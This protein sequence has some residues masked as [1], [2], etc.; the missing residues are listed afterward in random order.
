MIKF[1]NFLAEAQ[2]S[3]GNL[4]KVADIFKRIVQKNLGIKL[5]RFGGDTGFCEIKDGVGILYI[6]QNKKAIR[7]NYIK[8]EIK[9]LTLWNK[10][11]LNKLG[12][13][14]VDL[15][16]LG[17]LEAGKKLI[18]II[19]APAAGKVAAYSSIAESTTILSEATRINPADFYEL[20][21]K[22]LPSGLKI[23]VVPWS[24]ITD[25][26]LSAGFQVPTIVRNTRV[27]G[28]K[29][30]TSR[31]DLTQLISNPNIETQKVSKENEPIYYMKITAQDPLSKKFLSVKGDKKAEDILKRA[32]DAVHNPDYASHM[33]DPDTRFGHMADLVKIVCRGNRNSLVIY[34]GAGIGKTYV[35]T[36]SIKSEGL[37]KGKDWILI[38]G[39]ITTSALYQTLFM[40]RKNTLLVFDDTDSIWSDAEAANILKAALDSYDERTISWISPRNTNVSLMSDDEKESYNSAIDGQIAKDP[41]NGKIK[42]PSEFD[43]SGRIV[44][45]SNLQEDKFDKAV[46]NRSA[47]INMQLTQEEIFTRMKSI[48]QFIGDKNV[49][50][51][52]KEEIFDFI[53]KA[54]SRGILDNVSM[55]T[56]VAAED[57]FKSGMDNWKD[58]LVY[59]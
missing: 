27:A 37:Q 33:L 22:N 46:L 16:G 39:K 51:I 1:R 29:G 14:T 7:L 10:F 38:K 23:S 18:E 43:Y 5:Y 49:P 28:T 21:N 9:S 47:K 57:L 13:F 59:Q 2:V 17:L 48:L 3:K 50:M 24:V 12:D 36:E 41:G 25:I 6:A 15:A 26:A 44:F 52:V 31:F 32:S 56:F 54:S 19:K 53:Y 4:N 55:R 42:L 8:G 30:P 35:V 11:A 45:I 40:H 34:G 20:V 58:L